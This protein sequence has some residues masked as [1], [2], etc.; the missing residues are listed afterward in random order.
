[1]LRG[2]TEM[3]SRGDIGIAQFEYNWRWVFS[4]TYLRDAFELIAN[5]PRYSLGKVTPKGIEFYDRWHH[6]L[7]TFREANFVLV[8]DDW[9]PAFPS[10]EWWGD[11][12]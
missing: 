4:R 7:E 12:R 6:E 10:I 5:L 2:A 9:R 8:R 11:S 1:M 3:L